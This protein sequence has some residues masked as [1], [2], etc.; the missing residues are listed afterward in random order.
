MQPGP[1]A[2]SATTPQAEGPA[3][4]TKAGVGERAAPVR[5][6]AAGAVRLVDDDA[7]VVVTGE[8][9]DAGERGDVAVHREHGVGDDQR[10]TTRG[11]LQ[12]PLEVVEVA[13][14]VD[15]R[16]GA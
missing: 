1:G 15:H 8:L 9:D 12:R 2:P 4:P 6:H 7:A 10:C 16:L 3:G 14:V 5:A 11:F 13:V